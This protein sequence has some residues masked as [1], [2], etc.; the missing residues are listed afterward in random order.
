M[1]QYHL[2]LK[3]A[4]QYKIIGILHKFI[5]IVFIGVVGMN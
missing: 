4:F 1:N 5:V 3:A 2:V